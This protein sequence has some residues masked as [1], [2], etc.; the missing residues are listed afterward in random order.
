LL[1]IGEQAVRMVL[2][3]PE[4]FTP[5]RWER[6]ARA[7]LTRAPIRPTDGSN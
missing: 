5:D 6:F 7:L 1:A 2:A 3:D 4:E